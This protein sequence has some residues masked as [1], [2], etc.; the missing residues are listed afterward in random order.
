L[1]EPSS[2]VEN[3]RQPA[4]GTLNSPLCSCVSITLAAA[5]RL[6]RAF[7]RACGWNADCVRGTAKSNTRVRGEF[8]RV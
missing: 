7:H 6:R 2:G 5:S 4:Q 1:N 8:D 3:E